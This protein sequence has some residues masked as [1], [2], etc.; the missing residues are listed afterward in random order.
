M[1]L[2]FC[3]VRWSW[4]ND[5][6]GCNY[7]EI[8]LNSKLCANSRHPVQSKISQ[9]MYNQF[10]PI[11][12]ILNKG[13]TWEYLLKHWATSLMIFFTSTLHGSQCSNFSFERLSL[14]S[15]CIL[16]DS[17]FQPSVQTNWRIS[18]FASAKVRLFCWIFCRFQPN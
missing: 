11:V 12:R 16:L 10:Q 17:L 2:W 13:K 5:Y 4:N 1:L 8:K 7:W 14:P 6:I 18:G 15:I 9:E 3:L